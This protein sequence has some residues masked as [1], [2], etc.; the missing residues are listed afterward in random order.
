MES[1]FL[2]ERKVISLVFNPLRDTV[3]I[4][5][6]D[7]DKLDLTE[8]DISKNIILR[9]F[10]L[11]K[12]SECNIQNVNYRKLPKDTYEG[13]NLYFWELANKLIV[14]YPFGYLLIY[15]Y[16]TSNL[17]YHFQC[18]GKKAYMIRNLTGSPIQRSLFFSAETMRNIYLL[19]YDSN[20][21]VY[22]KMKIPQNETV[23][24]LICHP[25]EKFIFVA[26]SDS[27]IKI[28][29]YSGTRITEVKNGLVD[30]MLGKD[31]KPMKNQ[32]DLIKKSGIL[33]VVTLDINNN[34]TYLLSGNENGFIYLWDAL[35]AIK[36][37][38]ILL[39]KDKFSGTGILSVRFIK[40]KQFENLN[41][42]IC[43]TKEGKFYILNV[44]VKEQDN[45]KVYIFNKLY[46]NSIFSAINYSLSKYNLFTSNF[47][48]ISYFTNRI[49]LR[50]PSLRLDKIRITPEKSEDYLLFTNFTAK[51][52]FIYDNLFPKINFA[53]GTNMDFKNYEEYIPITSKNNLVFE[54]KLFFIDNFFIYYYDV[55]T[56]TSKK[57]FNY[58]REFN[59]KAIIP[60]KF[61]AHL[62]NFNEIAFVILIENEYNMKSVLF[63]NYDLT[64]SA[65][66][67]A[68]K[69]EDMIDF[70]ILGNEEIFKDLFLLSKNKQTA[71]ILNLETQTKQSKNIDGTIL[72]VY[73]TPF[74]NG[75]T[76]LYRNILNEL[77]FSA[78]FKSED[79]FDFKNIND[80]CFRL[81]YSE[82][83]I[84]VIWKVS[85][86]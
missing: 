74:C 21:P 75:H 8:E 45:T 29:D 49:C 6:L 54:R 2:L 59:L 24:D 12:T 31:N 42:F 65:I 22:I 40:T 81:D 27:I 85:S 32:A 14:I 78:N 17:T 60:L 63:I 64:T 71:I 55:M 73:W 5:S 39:N 68:Q 44:N 25:N 47:I 51:C 7:E 82:R 66:K 28:F 62:E 3:F 4:L 86:L 61:E 79:Q 58:S 15:D 34:G 77:K 19:N 23:Y 83:E 43:Q 26:L 36:N 46:E 30:V 80:N 41:R 56:G 57:L 10:R 20:K 1:S 18:Q 37:K 70:V 84:D 76:V 13:Y 33:S 35:S 9:R 53:L 67:L 50:W 48:S 52:F 72:R 11:L 69:F 16:Q 38:R